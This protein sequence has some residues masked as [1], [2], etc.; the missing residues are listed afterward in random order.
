MFKGE[1]LLEHLAL[2]RVSLSSLTDICER[3]SENIDY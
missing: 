3:E 2:N 1:R